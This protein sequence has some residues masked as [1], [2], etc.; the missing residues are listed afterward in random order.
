MKVI[1]TISFVRAFGTKGKTKSDMTKTVNNHVKCR[2]HFSPEKDPPSYLLASKPSWF[3]GVGVHE[4]NRYIALVK[5][6]KLKPTS[7]GLPPNE[8]QLVFGLGDSK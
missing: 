5:D 1:D 2:Q 3:W 8:P 4:P 6:I 7:V